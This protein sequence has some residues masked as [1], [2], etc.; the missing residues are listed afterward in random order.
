MFT[1]QEPFLSNMARRSLN[2]HEDADWDP[3]SADYYNPSFNNYNEG[4]GSRLDSQ[5][6]LFHPK[7][8]VQTFYCHTVLFIDVFNLYYIPQY[9]RV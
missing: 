8:V 4:P 7:Y 5:L 9:L 3:M 6:Q 1:F 2:L